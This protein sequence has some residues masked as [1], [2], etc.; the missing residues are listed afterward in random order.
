M[1]KLVNVGPSTIVASKFLVILMVVLPVVRYRNDNVF[2]KGSR[3]FLVARSI[4][5]S[6]TNI[7]T[8]YAI[9]HLSLPDVDIIGA[10]GA[11]FACVPSRIFLQEKITTSHIINIVQTLSE[12]L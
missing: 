6:V 5:G 12:W 8:Y 2:P 9:K 3:L 4:L 7:I 1:K 10:T 11:V